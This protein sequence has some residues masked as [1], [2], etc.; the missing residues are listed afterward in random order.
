MN[1]DHR[2]YII[3]ASGTGKTTLAKAIAKK[4]KCVHLDSDDFYHYPTDPPYSKQR[5][6]EERAQLLSVA[7]EPH[8]S[9]VLSGGAGT[10]DPPVKLD[11]TLAIFLYLSPEVR[12]ERLRSRESELHGARI[13]KGGDM[14]AIHGEFMNWTKGYDDGKSEGTNTLPVHLDFIDSVKSEV[15]RLEKSQTT[16]EQL[17]LVLMKLGNLY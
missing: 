17:H 10:W 6:P 7:L 15:L 9:W 11:F 13:L 5:T 14:E 12:L 8:S 2:V 4:L 1:I 16:D 3:G